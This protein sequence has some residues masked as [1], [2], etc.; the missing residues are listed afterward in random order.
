MRIFSYVM[1]QLHGTWYDVVNIP[2]SNTPLCWNFGDFHPYQ[3]GVSFT[4]YEYEYGWDNFEQFDRNYRNINRTYWRGFAQ[5]T[6]SN[7][8]DSFP[9]HREFL[10]VGR[11][12]Y[13]DISKDGKRLHIFVSRD[14]PSIKKYI[15]S[16]TF[17]RGTQ[18]R[19]KRSVQR[20]HASNSW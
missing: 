9:T 2:K 7:F 6:F 16:R 11:G 5:T 8:K 19:T 14:I 4:S 18:H 15:Y 12:R 1:F 20:G 13:M 3:G 10:H 17:Q